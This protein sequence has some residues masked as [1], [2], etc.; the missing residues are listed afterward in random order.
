MGKRSERRARARLNELIYKSSRARARRRN[1]SEGEWSEKEDR[2]GRVKNPVLCALPQDASAI[3][4]SV[5]HRKLVR[6]YLSGHFSREPTRVCVCVY[7]RA[8]MLAV[9]L[10]F[11]SSLVLKIPYI[12]PLYRIYRFRQ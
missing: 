6:D 10:F 7:F 4:A 5:A 11:L 2:G 9:F 3:L 1:T 12:A 8:D